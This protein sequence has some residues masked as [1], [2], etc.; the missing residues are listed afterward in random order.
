MGSAAGHSGCG[1]SAK[2][3][4]CPAK[5]LELYPMSREWAVGGK[6]YVGHSKEDNWRRGG[7]EP[8]HR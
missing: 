1:Q 7:W 6:V 4:E 3:L 8:G 5:A 2:D